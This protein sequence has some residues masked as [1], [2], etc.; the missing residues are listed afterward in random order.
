[1]FSVKFT[2][3][4]R[5]I[6]SLIGSLALAFTAD[7]AAAG[8][9]LEKLGDQVSNLPKVIL[10]G[11]VRAIAPLVAGPAVGSLVDR[12]SEAV[13]GS[14]GK[15]LQGISGNPT[16][17]MNLPNVQFLQAVLAIKALRA[18]GTIK[19]KEDCYAVSAKVAAAVKLDA[20]QLQSDMTKTLGNAA[21]DTAIGA[22]APPLVPQGIP[23]PLGNSPISL[24]PQ[25]ITQLGTAPG[26][27]GFTFAVRPVAKCTAAYVPPFLS[28]GPFF[29]LS[30]LVAMKWDPATAAWNPIA[31]LY[32]DGSGLFVLR[33]P[34][35]TPGVQV[36]YT[37]TGQMY[38]VRAVDNG[39]VFPSPVG[40]CI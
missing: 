30:N 11:D 40:Q 1:M 12:A 20:S 31:Q 9:F 6:L 33:N 16:A 26:F 36:A 10:K 24:P 14:I 27:G 17:L 23:D 29:L 5:A 2:L 37:A 38:L 35:D 32:L 13:G 22:G 25:A 18:N 7:T 39:L 4:S 8:G 3:K 28:G 15:T 21:C 34:I 19:E